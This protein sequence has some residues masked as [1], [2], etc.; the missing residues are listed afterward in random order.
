MNPQQKPVWL[1]FR[2]SLRMIR[3]EKWLYLLLIPGILYY[4]IF[5][6]KPMWGII[7]A[8]EN[9]SIKKGV[10]GSPWVGFSNF[11]RFFQSPSFWMLFRNTT[12]L[13]LTNLVFYFPAP[14]ILALLLNEVKH[15]KFKRT[16][17]SLTYLPHFLSWVII[18]GIFQNLF[19]A[20][21]GVVNLLIQQFTGH[22]ISFLESSFW[23]RPLYLLQTVWKEIG[24]GT[25]IFLAALS[26]VDLTLY[27]AAVVDGAGHWKRMLHITLP[28]IMPTIITLLILRMG[29]FLNTGFEQI[30][31]LRNTM[32]RSVSEV[33]D[34]YVYNIGITGGQFS[35]A[36]AIGLFKSAIG[37]VLVFGA[38]RLA[39]KIGQEGIL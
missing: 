17:Q 31:M 14:I 9:Y 11:V 27:E 3:K 10:F 16:V 23:F 21:G 36:T 26:S 15:I 8:F 20:E 38:D 4:A 25:I 19:S 1:G 28:C 18:Y 33:F 35:Y 30:F 13:A 32:N 5:C 12:V 22:T 39:K 24:W 37:L 34:T 29:S 6:Y 2:G 7:Y